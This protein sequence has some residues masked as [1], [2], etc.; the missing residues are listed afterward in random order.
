MIL[1]DPAARPVIAHRGASGEYPENTLLAFTKAIEQGA[2]ALELDVRLTRDGVPVVLHD[3]ALDRTTDLSGPVEGLPWEEVRQANAG[4]GQAIPSLAQVLER[5]PATPLVIEIKTPRAAL[6]VLSVLREH[7]ATDRVLVGAFERAALAPFDRTEVARAASRVEVARFWLA[8]RWP[9]HSP[10][11][12][13][14]AF[15]VPRRSGWLRV[16]DGRF[17]ASARRRGLPVHVWT[18]DDLS[19][20]EHLRE[21]G[22]CGIITNFP[23]RMRDL[24]RW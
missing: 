17:V 19:E 8:A 21:L 14:R 4:A 10:R 5:F 9:G 2:D 15:T 1:L 3:A 13:W 22:V 24:G 7:R 23:G 12:S 18:V 11:A 6:P 20:A 16:A